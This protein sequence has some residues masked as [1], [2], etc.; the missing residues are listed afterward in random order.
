MEYISHRMKS[1]PANGDMAY[2]LFNK[3]SI[4][5]IDRIFILMCL[6]NEMNQY[7]MNSEE[8]AI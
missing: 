3:S 4:H 5:F 6:K 8:T 2:N 7:E 1:V